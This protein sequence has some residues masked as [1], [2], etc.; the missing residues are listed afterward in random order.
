MAKGPIRSLCK[1]KYEMEI[2]E[3][4]EKSADTTKAYPP[5]GGDNAHTQSL[6]KHTMGKRLTYHVC[7]EDIRVHIEES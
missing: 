2:E 6:E 4:I 3:P 1:L 5:N 7:P